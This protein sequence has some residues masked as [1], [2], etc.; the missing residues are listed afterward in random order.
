MLLDVF[1]AVDSYQFVHV[2]NIAGDTVDELEIGFQGGIDETY[3]LTPD[4]L[5][6][7]LAGADLNLL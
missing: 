5:P 6:R 4:L 3:T 7:V 2:T 1:L